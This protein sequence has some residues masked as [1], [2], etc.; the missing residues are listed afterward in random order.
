MDLRKYL[1]EKGYFVFEIEE[2]QERESE[3][4]H[5]QIIEIKDIINDYLK[6]LGF[7]DV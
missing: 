6:E 3:I 2:A 1:F 7:Y 5:S 4:D